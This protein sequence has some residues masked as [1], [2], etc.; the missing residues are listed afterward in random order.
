MIVTQNYKASSPPPPPG[1]DYEGK[2]IPT[3]EG[4]LAS[5][6]EGPGIKFSSERVFLFGV[7]VGSLQVL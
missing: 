6:Q 3:K 1:W 5:Q 2:I 7:C 4:V